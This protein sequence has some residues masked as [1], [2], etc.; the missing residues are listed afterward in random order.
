MDPTFLSATSL[1]NHVRAGKIGAMELLDHYIASV[2]QHDNRINAIVVRD[3]ERARDHARRLDS[4]T[5]KSA[6]LFGVPMTVKESFDVQGLPTTRGHVV[7]K[8]RPMVLSSLPVRRLQ[9]AGA[10]VFGKTNVPVDLAD[11]QS[12]NQFT[13][14]PPTHG[15]PTTRPAGPP[16]DRRRR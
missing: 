3:I 8:D 15:I 11:W 12:Y 14:P 5:D 10:V 1:A 4:E 2:E 9:A 7:A 6:P 16:A 13:A